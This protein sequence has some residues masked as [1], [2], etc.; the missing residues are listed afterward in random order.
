M[1]QARPP[2]ARCGGNYPAHRVRRLYAVAHLTQWGFVIAPLALPGIRRQCPQPVSRRRAS[3]QESGFT[4]II[5]RGHT[6]Y[7]QN[8]GA[9]DAQVPARPHAAR[10][11]ADEPGGPAAVPVPADA[12]PARDAPAAG[13][14]PPAED[15]SAPA[16]WA[17]PADVAPQPG[18][19]ARCAA[20]FLPG[21][22][23]A[24]GQQPQGDSRPQAFLP[25][26]CSRRLPCFQ[27]LP[28][29]LLQPC[30]RRSLC[31]PALP[32]FQQLP[33]SR[34]RP[35]SQLQLCSRHL[36]CSRLRL[37]F[38]LPPCFRQESWLQQRRTP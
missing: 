18:A 25:V 12:A 24:T 32:C 26:P 3:G 38:P 6:Q 5:K 17:E 11:V 23:D 36:P 28:C 19:W 13:D 22:P 8:P 34:S 27:P 37:C 35:C 1:R 9:S 29:S 21:R 15:A 31:S 16:A 14:V 33:C 2:L 10:S 20:R 30:S 7:R 4:S